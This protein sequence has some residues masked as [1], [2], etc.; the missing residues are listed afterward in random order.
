ML[1]DCELE[2]L[3]NFEWIV[4]AEEQPKPWIVPAEK[5]PK[6]WIVPAEE[7]PK[8]WIVLAEEQPK[9]WIVPAEEQPKPWI[10]PAEEQPKPGAS[11]LAGT[12]PPSYPDLPLESTVQSECFPTTH[13]TTRQ[14]A[15]SAHHPAVIEGPPQ[16]EQPQ[17][18]RP[19]QQPPQQQLQQGAVQL[20]Q[21]P[22]EV[23]Q[24]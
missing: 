3:L 10:V 11:H 14:S 9:P 15:H 8:P 23:L 24:Y 1:D 18:E 19:Q 13:Q 17:Q 16:Q 5:Q 2:S 6:P 20:L 7:Q 4:P 12:L 21:D 22:A